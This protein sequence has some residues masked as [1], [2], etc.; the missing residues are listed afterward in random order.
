MIFPDIAAEDSLL[1]RARQGDGRAVMEIYERYFQP[2]Y[3]FVRLRTD[4]AALAEDIAADVFLKLVTAFKS[5][6]GAPTYSLRGWLFQVARGEL[7][8][9]YGR[10]KRYSETTLDDWEPV[11]SNDPDLEADYIRRI[12]AEKARK[13]LRMLNAEQQEVLILRFGQGLNLEE[14]ADVMGKSVSAVKS[15]Q[16][17]AVNTLR[18]ILGVEG[19]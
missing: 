19:T 17:R 15:L 14:T 9:Q 3:Q 11:E 5:G 13:A 7:S 8:R 18:G 1:A 4:D 12:G 6:R 10:S 2:I 16:S